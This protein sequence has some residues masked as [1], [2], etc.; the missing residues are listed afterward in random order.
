MDRAPMKKPIRVGGRQPVPSRA[1]KADLKPGRRSRTRCKP[2]RLSGPKSPY[3]QG[4]V[5]ASDL[6]A[7]DRMAP[8]IIVGTDVSKATLVITVGTSVLRVHIALCGAGM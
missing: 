4:R 3:L 8:T 7:G 2:A 5:V 1:E 6:R